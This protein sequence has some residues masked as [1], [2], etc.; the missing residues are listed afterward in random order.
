MK[1]VCVLLADGFEE[2]EG[3]TVVDLLRRAKIYVDTV[4]IMDDY[5]VHGAHGINV[6]TEDLFDE[7]DFEEFD[8]VCITW[9]YAGNIKFKR[10]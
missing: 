4:S 9:R 2:I 1:K 3:L 6:Q 7:V 5:I 8:M 10:T